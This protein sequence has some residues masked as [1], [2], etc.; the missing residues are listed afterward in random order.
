MMFIGKR[1]LLYLVRETKST[2]ALT[3]EKVKGSPPTSSAMYRS[4]IPRQM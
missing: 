3:G 4:N 2:H 1:P